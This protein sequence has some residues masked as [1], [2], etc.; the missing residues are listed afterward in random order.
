LVQGRPQPGHFVLLLRPP[1]K[2]KRRRRR[3][4]RRK[5]KKERKLHAISLIYLKKKFFE[6]KIYISL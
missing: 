1:K 4:R 5:K 3:R 2:P 6:L